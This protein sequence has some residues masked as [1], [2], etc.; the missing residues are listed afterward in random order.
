MSYYVFN[1]RGPLTGDVVSWQL[2]A[3][4]HRPPTPLLLETD[5]GWVASKG[6][7]KRGNYGVDPRQLWEAGVVGELKWRV[8]LFFFFDLDVCLMIFGSLKS[9][10]MKISR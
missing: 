5:L 3:K 2:A 7:W 9:R 4:S 1:R 10:L 6:R 8:N